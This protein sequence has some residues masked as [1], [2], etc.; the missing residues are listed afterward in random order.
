VCERES[1]Y[2]CVC[3]SDGDTKGEEKEGKKH[4]K[5]KQN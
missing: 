5:Q 4:K 1:M 3:V 2:V